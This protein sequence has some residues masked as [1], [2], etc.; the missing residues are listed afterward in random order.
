MPMKVGPHCIR[1]NVSSFS[2]VFTHFNE[3]SKRQP[4]KL[5]LSRCPWKVDICDWASRMRTF[6][7]VCMFFGQVVKSNY[8]KLCG[9]PFT[10]FV[11]MVKIIVAITLM[12]SQ[13]L[14]NSP[15]PRTHSFFVIA[16]LITFYA[17]EL[18][19]PASSSYF[20]ELRLEA[21]LIR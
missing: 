9:Q 2:E 12:G 16:G 14:N 7:Q 20:Y 5:S 17:Y 3:I 18:Q 1:K 4:Q 10:S 21:G 11:A 15:L 19:R 6:G 13:R 8:F